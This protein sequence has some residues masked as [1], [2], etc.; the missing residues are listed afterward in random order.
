MA[1]GAMI[2]APVDWKRLCPEV[3]KLMKNTLRNARKVCLECK[4]RRARFRFR[5]VV[6][7]DSDHRLCMRCYRSLRDRVRT[8]LFGERFDL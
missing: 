7:W 4:E 2:A 6:K 8:Q 1:R 5:G 3:S